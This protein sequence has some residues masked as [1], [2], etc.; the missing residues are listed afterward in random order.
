MSKLINGLTAYSQIDT[1]DKVC[2][3][4]CEAVMNEVKDC[5]TTVLNEIHA[6]VLI[7]PLPSIVG[8]KRQVTSLFHHLFGNAVKFRREN[9]RLKIEVT[10]E[11]ILDAWKFSIKDNGIGIDPSYQHKIFQL[12]RRLHRN[13]DYGGIGVGLAQC[14]KIVEQ[15]GGQIWVESTEHLGSV[16]FFT[17][18]D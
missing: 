16:F 17:I 6:E 5:F 4:D 18:P 13:G 11:R 3:V 12:F 8:S 10:C 14:R 15:F 2:E 9:T 7:G 1:K